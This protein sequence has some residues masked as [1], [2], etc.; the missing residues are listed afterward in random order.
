ME[1][2][3]SVIALKVTPGKYG[4]AKYFELNMKLFIQL[5]IILLSGYY[6]YSSRNSMASTIS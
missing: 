3:V 5:L 1:L 2:N 6:Q 4:R